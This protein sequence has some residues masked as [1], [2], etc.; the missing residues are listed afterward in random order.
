MTDHKS[1]KNEFLTICNNT[2]KRA[3]SAYSTFSSPPSD[4]SKLVVHYYSFSCTLMNSVQETDSLM[5]KLSLGIQEKDM[6]D[7]HQAVAALHSLFEHC[8]MLRKNIEDFLSST[9]LAKDDQNSFLSAFKLETDKL[10]R[11]TLI[12]KNSANSMDLL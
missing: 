8:A 10:I 6:A 1:Y 11:K 3:E 5:L 9:E 2:V 7:R 4:F 12:L